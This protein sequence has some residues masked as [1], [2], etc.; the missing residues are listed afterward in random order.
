MTNLVDSLEMLQSMLVVVSLP[1]LRLPGSTA[2]QRP[3]S[4]GTVKH[5]TGIGYIGS[6]GA[7]AHL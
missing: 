5:R 3:R 6:V 4:D 2:S 7:V 1:C